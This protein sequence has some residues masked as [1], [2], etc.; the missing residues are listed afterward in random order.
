[1]PRNL[2]E[3]PSQTATRCLL[4]TQQ[5]TSAAPRKRCRC[6][7]SRRLTETGSCSGTHESWSTISRCFSLF[8]GSS[9]AFVRSTT[10]IMSLPS[11][12]AA[13]FLMASSEN[14]RT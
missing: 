4:T 1:V 10:L 8:L 3:K 11:L 9:E 5:K 7:V 2:P 12:L 14:P 13:F 6:D